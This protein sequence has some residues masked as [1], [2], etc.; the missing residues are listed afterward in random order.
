VPLS[1]DARARSVFS[2]FSMKYMGSC[3]LNRKT[4]IGDPLPSLLLYWGSFTPACYYIY[5]GSFTQ[6]S[7]ILGIL[8]PVCYCIGDLLPQPAT[9]LGIL[10][11]LL[12]V[13]IGNP[14]NRLTLI[15]SASISHLNSQLHC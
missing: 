9:I 7:T 8:Y 13:S 5:W 1:Y 10:S 11:L 15:D 4:Y 14:Y 2:L 3:P 6:P 12:L